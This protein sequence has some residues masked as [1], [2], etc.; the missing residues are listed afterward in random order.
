MVDAS[1]LEKLGAAVE[2]FDFDAALS[3]LGEVVKQFGEKESE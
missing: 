1:Q 2:S 3:R